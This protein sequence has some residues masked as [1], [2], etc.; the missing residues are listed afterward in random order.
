MSQSHTVNPLIIR[1]KDVNPP[2]PR[3][4]HP[5]KLLRRN[6]I[7]APSVL[8]SNLRYFLWHGC[9]HHL[10]HPE[11]TL[12]RTEGVDGSWVHEDANKSQ[13]QYASTNFNRTPRCGRSN[14]PHHEEGTETELLVGRDNQVEYVNDTTL[15]YM[16]NSCSAGPLV[17][18]V[19]SC[20]R[21][22]A[23]SGM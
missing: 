15:G 4:W 3:E 5:Y 21:W 1:D 7:W 14:V 6:R 19:E 2:L 9:V 17:L 16:V 11:D 22:W 20:V 8:V 12:T 23:R 10:R 13:R 18:G